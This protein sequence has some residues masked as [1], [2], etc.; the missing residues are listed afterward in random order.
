MK[1]STANYIQAIT[2]FKPY[3]CG[4]GKCKVVN[5]TD[6]TCVCKKGY[7]FTGETCTDINECQDDPC[8]NG[9]CVNTPGTY[10]LVY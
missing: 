5:V 9:E 1:M 8:G 2:D 3:R 10:T 6:F 4:M 7:E